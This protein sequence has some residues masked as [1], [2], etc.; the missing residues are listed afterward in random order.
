MTQLA[1]KHQAG[2]NKI[3]VSGSITTHSKSSDGILT[4]FNTDRG[5]I[6]E[7]IEILLKS[8]SEIITKGYRSHGI[9]HFDY[10][11]RE[12]RRKITLEKGSTISTEYNNSV[13]IYNT[14]NNDTIIYGD[15][16]T[17][18]NEAHGVQNKSV[19]NTVELYGTIVTG[20]KGSPT[21]GKKAYGIT[22]EDGSD[23]LIGSTA[24]NNGT[25]ITYGNGSYGIKNE[26]RTAGCKYTI[27]IENGAG[28]QTS[29]SDAHGVY[30]EHNGAETTVAGNISTSGERSYGV[31]N[32]GNGNTTVVEEDGTINIGNSGG[33]DAVGVY[34]N[35]DKNTTTVSGEIRTG[36]EDE[37]NQ[38]INV[39]SYGVYNN[40][41]ANLT[42]VSS[43]GQIITWGGSAHAILNE[44]TN[45]IATVF[46]GITTYGLNSAGIWNEPGSSEENNHRFG[47]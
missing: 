2:D 24:G 5:D 12:A 41:D 18:G 33:N 29:G 46:G 32:K 37:I 9:R 39:K 1:L 10:H 47:W 14:N 20:V 4:K 3:I 6:D 8:G 45:N 35:G 42:T 17:A 23:V 21:K 7:P 26:C 28:I 22:N 15:V 11:P 25:I 30:I 44:G 36:E 40:G 31:Y 34:N 43:N 13:G 19:N 38:E 16:K 27:N